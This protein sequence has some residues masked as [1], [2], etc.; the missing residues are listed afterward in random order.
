MA[1]TQARWRG[2]IDAGHDTLPASGELFAKELAEALLRRPAASMAICV[3]LLA[4]VWRYWRDAWR[5]WQVA[6]CP[7]LHPESSRS[8][9]GHLEHLGIAVLDQLARPSVEDEKRP[10]LSLGEDVR[11]MRSHGLRPRHLER[12]GRYLNH[13]RVAI[14]DSRRGLLIE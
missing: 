9:C 13:A 7:I 14:E 12:L 10:V 11:K 5:Y 8:G 3:A 4:D 1:E 2:M 6:W